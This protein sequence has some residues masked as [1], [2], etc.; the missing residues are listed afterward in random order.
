MLLT[1]VRPPLSKFSAKCFEQIRSISLS[2]Y[3]T[4]MHVIS[5]SNGGFEMKNQELK[6]LVIT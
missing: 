4:L 6:L 1:H 3:K 2:A 5:N